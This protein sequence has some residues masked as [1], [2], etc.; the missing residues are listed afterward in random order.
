[1]K[2]AKRDPFINRND[3]IGYLFMLPFILGFVFLFLTPMVTS[4]IYSFNE[5]KMEASGLSMKFVGFA[6]YHQA[7]FVDAK[8]FKELLTIAGSV[9]V[10]SLV[11]MFW[12]MF[13]AMLLNDKFTGRLF[14]RTV[15][16]LPVI[17]GADVVM[18]IFKMSPTYADMIATTG[19]EVSTA[20]GV[21]DFLTEIINSFGFLSGIMT[22]FTES[23]NTLF[24]MTWEMG[25]QVVLFIVGFQSI[26]SHL[27][28]VCDIEGAT[29]WETF[30]KITFPLLTPTILLCLIYTV[31]DTF[32]AD[33]NI[34]EMITENMS[35][36]LHYASAQTWLY[37]LLVIVIVAVIYGAVSRKTIY[38]D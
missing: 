38:L 10:K 1:M 29:K 12:S 24:E 22:T 3:I 7:L 13:I 37:A 17:F 27:Y 31:I 2:K 33:N 20:Q 19:G 32:N 8:F 14:F 9:T 4:I 16:F 25:I 23:V 34:N 21:T 6:N 36:T 28:E 18:N 11:I 26:P 35:L 5:V 15:M 30:W